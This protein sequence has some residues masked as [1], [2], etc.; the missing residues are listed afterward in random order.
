ML[1]DVALLRKFDFYLDGNRINAWE[2][3][4]H[5]CREWRNIVFESPRRLDLQLLC[6]DGTSVRKLR[7]IWP[8]LPL[9]VGATELKSVNMNNIFAVLE[10]SDHIRQFQFYLT[11]R[12]P[13][14]EGTPALRHLQLWSHYG[15]RRGW[16]TVR[17]EVDPESF[18]GGSAP[19]LQSLL[20]HSIPFLGLPKAL[21]SAT[22]LVDIHLHGIPLSPED[23]FP[24]FA[25]F[26]RLEKFYFGNTKDSLR[27]SRNLPQ[28]TRT[29]LPSLTTFE[30]FGWNESFLNDL[31][32]QID[33]PL[34]DDLELVFNPTSG[35]GHYPELN[36]LISRTAKFEAQDQAHVIFKNDFDGPRVRVALPQTFHRTLSLGT[37]YI[38]S[39]D[40]VPPDWD[41][42]SHMPICKSS[43]PQSLI[44][45]VEHLYLFGPS[46]SGYDDWGDEEWVEIFYPFPAV[47]S[48]HISYRFASQIALSLGNLVGE[49]VTE[50]LPALESLF[51]EEIP[52]LEPVK[53][54][55]GRFLLRDSLPAAL[56]SF[57][58]GM[59]SGTCTV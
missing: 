12:N 53:E 32:A 50:V 47:K 41:L 17:W 36:D 58:H 45:A 11:I 28:T 15:F 38:Y 5:V 2:T 59:M 33:V 19:S 39:H 44:L 49:R 29:L 8:L 30:F 46:L 43:F 27:I 7:D 57:V 31:L 25:V 6:T 54:A 24:A 13:E 18:L 23:M 35:L 26:T 42:W 37:S 9:A 10:H 34:L 21:L 48:L 20:L 40:D 55:F 1:P 14:W 22:H 56:Y 3:L 52:H 16:G 51:I 4:V